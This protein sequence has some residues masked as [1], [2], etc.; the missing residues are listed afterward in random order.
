WTERRAASP[1]CRRH[2]AWDRRVTRRRQQTPCHPAVAWRSARRTRPRPA[3]SP[4]IC[5]G[6]VR[7]PA[8]AG[9]DG[10]GGQCRAAIGAVKERRRGGGRLWVGCGQEEQI[11]GIAGVVIEALHSL[12]VATT[13]SFVQHRPWCRQ[14]HEPYAGRVPTEERH[15]RSPL[16]WLAGL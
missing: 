11:V 9:T 14:W 12:R 3:L 2:W 13:Y 1:R 15:G 7:A 10:L 16:Y 8:G 6:A 5:R 4:S